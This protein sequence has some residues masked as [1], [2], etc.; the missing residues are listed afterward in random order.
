M[1]KRNKKQ[2]SYLHF[3]LSCRWPGCQKREQGT[4]PKHKAVLK[5]MAWIFPASGQIGGGTDVGPQEPCT[6]VNP[7]GV[8]E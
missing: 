8:K 5:F 7:S 4:K 1:S 3:L 2:E 6:Y